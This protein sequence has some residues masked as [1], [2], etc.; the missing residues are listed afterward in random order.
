LKSFALR[1]PFLTLAVV[2]ALFLSWALPTL[3]AASPAAYAP[4]DAA[5]TSATVV[6]AQLGPGLGSLVRMGASIRAALR[7]IF[8]AAPA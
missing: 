4:E 3:L 5:R 8:T 2:T 7:E 1:V 6:M